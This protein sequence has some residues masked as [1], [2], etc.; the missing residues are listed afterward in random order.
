MSEHDLIYNVEIPI[1]I[2]ALI[3]LVILL[4][5]ILIMY[6]LDKFRR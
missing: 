4:G 5:T 3:T 1:M 6:L 2:G